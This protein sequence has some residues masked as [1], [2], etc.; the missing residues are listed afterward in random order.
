VT[1]NT[2]SCT[3][4]SITG[5]ISASPVRAHKGAIASLDL[6]K[7]EEEEEEEEEGE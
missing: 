1:L 6:P 4:P 5:L 7:S 2:T 3:L